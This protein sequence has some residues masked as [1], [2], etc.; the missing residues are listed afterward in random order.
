MN[1]FSCTLLGRRARKLQIKEA[2]ITR[3][4]KGMEDHLRLIFQPFPQQ[5]YAT[6]LCYSSS[7]NYSVPT[8][9]TT[10]HVV[11]YLLAPWS[12]VLFEKLTSSRLIKKFP[13]FHGTRRFITA[14]TSAHYLSLS[15]TRSIQSIPQSHFW[16]SILILSYY[17]RLGL[18]SSLFPSGFPAKTMFVPLLSSCVLYALPTS[19]SLFYDPNNIWWGVQIIKLFVM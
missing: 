15:W 2:A 7:F 4:L 17:L 5:T 13:A 16:R 3:S 12:R 6:T 8:E 1:I 10:W 14:F 11:I 9:E 19:F 18:P